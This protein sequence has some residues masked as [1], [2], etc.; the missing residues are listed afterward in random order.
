MKYFAHRSF[1][2]TD[3]IWLQCVI[4]SDTSWCKYTYVSATT[5]S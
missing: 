4:V 2:V 3:N 1:Q 5:Y